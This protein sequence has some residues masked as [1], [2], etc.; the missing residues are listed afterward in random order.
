MHGLPIVSYDE[1]NRLSRITTEDGHV[2]RNRYDAEG[3]RAEMEE[4]G[5]KEAEYMKKYNNFSKYFNTNPRL[6]I[7]ILGI[8]G[9]IFV[10]I[11]TV[12]LIYAGINRVGD[13]D[14]NK[15]AISIVYIVG[16]IWCIAASISTF[17]SF[18]KKYLAQVTLV[19]AR[20]GKELERRGYNVVQSLDEMEAELDAPLLAQ[21]HSGVNRGFNFFIT[22]N[23]IIGTDDLIGMRA[24]AIRISDIA[25]VDLNEI[26]TYHVRQGG[27]MYITE[28]HYFRVK[29]MD[30]NNRIYCFSVLNE[31]CQREAYNWITK[32]GIVN[33]NE[34]RF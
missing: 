23:W 26:S 1:L 16:I 15:S 5:K 17:N 27:G 6:W 34:D 18:K 29:L 19:N 20:I 11:S 9:E 30:K 3:L 2:Q 31:K 8:V 12:I 7:I 22:E 25:S 14:G 32:N 24:N 21:I 13:S 10:V 28:K 33:A 4:D